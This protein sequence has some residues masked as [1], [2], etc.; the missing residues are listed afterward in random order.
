MAPARSFR[1]VALY[2]VQYVRPPARGAGC[3]TEQHTRQHR[4]RRARAALSN[5]GTQAG[6]RK[7]ER[8]RKLLLVVVHPLTPDTISLY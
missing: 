4:T 1:L 7:Q 2:A 6:S 8:L 3:G 5:T